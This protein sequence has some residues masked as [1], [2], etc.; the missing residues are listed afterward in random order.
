L[1]ISR[2]ASETSSGAPMATLKAE[3]FIFILVRFWA[4]AGYPLTAVSVRGFPAPVVRRY[5]GE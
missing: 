2:A 3:Y 4:S 5:R 1:S